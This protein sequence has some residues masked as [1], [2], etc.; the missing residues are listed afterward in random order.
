MKYNSAGLRVQKDVT[1]NGVTETTQYILNGK[2]V[3]EMICGTDKMHFFYD[4]Q[5]R[6]AKV[7]YNGEMYTY[8][9]NLQGDI[10]GIVDTSGTL[11]VEYKYDA[12]GR[13][14]A[15]TVASSANEAEKS[16]WEALAK[17]NPFR[18]RGYVY[19]EESRL[20]Y[21]RTRYYNPELQRFISMDD[22][23][24]VEV[25]QGTPL[26]YN[27]YS[28][29]HNNPVNMTDDSGCLPFFLAAGAVGAV[30]GGVIGAIATRSW[31]GALAGAAIGGAALLGIGSGFAAVVAGKATASV[32][33]VWIGTRLS[34][35]SLGTAGYTSYQAWKTAKGAAGTGR[36]WHHIVEQSE[37]NMEQFG[38]RIV[39]HA[40]NIVNIIHGK[41]TLHNAISAY[42][43]STQSFSKP[44]TVRKWLSTQSF[45]A[46][47]NFGLETLARLAREMGEKIYYSRRR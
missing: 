6:P 45:R 18:Y 28:Y 5:S 43:S 19:D 4:A 31:K 35:S 29:C 30:V 20:Y 11:V 39:Q 15:T 9:H 16:M 34:I 23:A 25:D 41:G 38:A 46:Q 37:N 26:Q 12:W 2:L 17:L 1:A 21:L 7:S 14:L 10:V 27:L 42:Y 32:G 8:L 22:V 24:I 44:L 47:Y 33:A 13:L 40:K 36:A 3:T